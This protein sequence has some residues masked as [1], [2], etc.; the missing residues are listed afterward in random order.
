MLSW[1]RAHAVVVMVEWTARVDISLQ[2]ECMSIVVVVAA[3]AA[4]AAAVHHAL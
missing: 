2:C 4:A 3:A 1:T